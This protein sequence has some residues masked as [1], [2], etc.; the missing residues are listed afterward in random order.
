[1]HGCGRREFRS[2]ALLDLPAQDLLPDQDA[3]QRKRIIWGLLR[4]LERDIYLLW[5]CAAVTHCWNTTG[6]CLE[7]RWI[8]SVLG[9]RIRTALWAAGPSTLESVTGQDAISRLSPVQSFRLLWENCH[10]RYRGR[11]RHIEV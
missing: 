9:P 2:T 8:E 10:A 1:M 7:F 4:C 3:L 5:I 6:R 11:G